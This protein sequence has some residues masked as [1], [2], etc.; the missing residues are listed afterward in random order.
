MEFRRTRASAA[1]LITKHSICEGLNSSPLSNESL[2]SPAPYR[3]RQFLVRVVRIPV[4][5]ILPRRSP[6]VH[7]PRAE[8][9]FAPRLREQTVCP[10]PRRMSAQQGTGAALKRFSVKVPR[11]PRLP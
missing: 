2:R 7:D 3:D 5:L 4:P 6:G 9:A 11:N 8:I 10:A 1:Y